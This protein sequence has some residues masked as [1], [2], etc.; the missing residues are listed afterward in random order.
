MEMSAVMAEGIRGRFAPSPTGFLHLGHAWVALLSWL[1]VRGS[2]GSWVLRVEDL[3]P[4]PAGSVRDPGPSSAPVRPCPP[5][6]GLGGP[7]SFQAARG[8]GLA[9]VAP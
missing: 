4:D 5:A 8:A 2:G 1:Q 3:D 9:G 7:A 6:G